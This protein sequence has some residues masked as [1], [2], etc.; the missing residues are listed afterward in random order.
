[1]K[2]VIDAL[3]SLFRRDL[4]RLAKELQL[5]KNEGN[6]WKIE[7]DIANS[8]GNLCLHL[9][10][11]LTTYIGKE[12]GSSGYV[13]NREE[14]FSLKNVPL[15]EMIKGIYRTISMVDRVLDRMDDND[16][17]ED[18]P[19][20]VFEYKTTTGYMLIHLTTHLSYHL[21]HVNYHRRLV[22]R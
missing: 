12:L 5:Y 8:A 2:T 10:G 22:D 7:C 1:M 3:K 21:G 18:F 14:E 11:N 9:L 19:V 15:S 17:E 6:I 4:E 20:L 16:L 13:R